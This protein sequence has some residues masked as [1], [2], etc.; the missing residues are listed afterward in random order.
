MSM[1]KKNV[2]VGALMAG[3]VVAG[4]ILYFVGFHGASE[5]GPG[6]ADPKAASANPG[7]RSAAP[8][9]ELRQEE[10]AQFKIKPAL[11]RV[12]TVEREAVGSISFNEELSTDVFPPVQGKV[13]KL[14][15]RAGD[16]VALGTPL[17]S[18]DSPDLVQAGSTL[19]AA[20]GTLDLTTK[21]LKRARELFEVQGASQKDLDQ[22]V[23]DQQGAEGAYRAARDAVRIFGKTDAEMDA[24]VAQRKIDSELVV[25]SPI[26][27]RVTARSAAPG[28]LVQPGNPPA[29]FAL[30]DIS[31]MWMLGEVAESDFRHLRLGLPVEVRVQAYPGRVFSATIVNIGSAVDPSTRRVSV[32][33]EIKDEKR[34]L[35]PGMFA[36]YLI[37]VGESGPSPAVSQAGV[38]REGD[39][40]MSVWVTTDQKTISRRTVK[41]G[42]EQDGQVQILEGLKPGELVANDAA[43]FLSNALTSI[44][45]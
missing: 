38:I 12:F 11:E 1:S 28:L 29:P 24:I 9:L 4:L 21:A 41:T 40:T 30:S 14:F 15:A 6:S 10:L 20:A 31:T 45:H 18:I 42:L 35:R 39:G 19:I 8:S 25:R 16:D 33:S 32:R 5:G 44:S 7:D 43:I 22:A 3:V 34:E 26:A 36:T 17:Y 23:S 2:M 27:G 13:L 37:K